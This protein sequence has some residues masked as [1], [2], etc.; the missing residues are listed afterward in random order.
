M[1]YFLVIQTWRENQNYT[2]KLF[3]SSNFTI[4]TAYFKT[5][6]AIEFQYNNLRLNIKLVKFK[7]LYVLAEYAYVKRGGFP[8]L[9]MAY[10]GVQKG[11]VWL[12]L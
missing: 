1:L 7:N 8:N 11:K 3:S 12:T 10:E 9:T 6:P 5:L 4:Y 2:V